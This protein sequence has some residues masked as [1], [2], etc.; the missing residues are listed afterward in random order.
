MR[1]LSADRVP[2]RGSASDF[3]PP[4]C[5]DNHYDCHRNV[6]RLSPI[7]TLGIDFFR[8]LRELHLLAQPLTICA[9]GAR[10]SLTFALTPV[11]VELFLELP[12]LAIVV[13][14]AAQEGRTEEEHEDQN[15][16]AVELHQDP[17]ALGTQD[18]R[19]GKGGD[20][21][22][23]GRQE[24]ED[25]Q[26][27]GHVVPLPRQRE[28]RPD[29]VGDAQSREQANDDHTAA[30]EALAQRP[31]HVVLV[32]QEHHHGTDHD[33]QSGGGEDTQKQ[34]GLVELLHRRLRALTH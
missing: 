19:T 26:L 12:V 23:H 11:R 31:E 22:Q 33:H 14:H 25:R 2:K 10:K 21:D 32:A 27:A 30:A 6:G 28:P 24:Q 18:H 9:Q 20:D 4:I 8:C 5:V 15:D 29:E 3:F 7:Q 34:G 17:R 16:P 1:T 13:S